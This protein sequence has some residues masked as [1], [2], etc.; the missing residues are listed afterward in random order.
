MKPKDQIRELGARFQ[1]E[2]PHME[3]VTG[4]AL[5]LFDGFGFDK[6]DRPLL[7]AAAR[8]HDIGYA[9]DPENHVD[10]GLKILADNPLPAFSSRDWKLICLIVSLHRRDWRSVLTEEVR[11]EFSEKRLE[12][13]KA[14]AAALR[15]ADGLDHSH[16]QDTSIRFCR[17]GN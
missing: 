1:I 11:A 3:Q 10:A 15:I 16:I 7:A 6:K 13:A 9:A 4:L 2:T 14:L 5:E 17:R 12:R 8:L